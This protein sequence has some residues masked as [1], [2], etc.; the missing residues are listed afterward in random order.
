[1]RWTA[2]SPSMQAGMLLSCIEGVV[3]LHAVGMDE[4]F[5]FC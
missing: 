3:A 2:L 4:A 1:M 5:S